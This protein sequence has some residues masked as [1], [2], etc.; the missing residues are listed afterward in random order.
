[1]IWY[2]AYGS[3]M[4]EERMRKRVGTWSARVPGVLAGWRLAFNKQ[5]D[6]K[7]GEGYANIVPSSDRT[8]EGVLYA[9]D[10]EALVVLDRYEG[11]PWHYRRE[12]LA[13]ERKDTG[14]TVEAVV[15]VA[16]PERVREGLRPSREYLH[17]LLAGRDCL[18][19]EYVQC[20]E[21][22]ETVD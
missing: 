10:E 20:L 19:A 12:R 18:S 7:P 21:R 2:F 13:V 4:D 14:E 8:V 6:N 9:V 1:M 15:Y 16:C 5:A 11:V 17:H 22:V 3:N